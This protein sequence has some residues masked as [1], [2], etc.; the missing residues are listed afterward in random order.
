MLYLRS[1][2]I[3]QCIV[4]IVRFRF[5]W[6]RRSYSYRLAPRYYNYSGSERVTSRAQRSLPTFVC[7]PTR[8]NTA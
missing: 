8:N 1:L 4:T 5:S 6:Q 7:G 3:D 2:T